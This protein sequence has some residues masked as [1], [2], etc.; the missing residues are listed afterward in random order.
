MNWQG[1]ILVLVIIGL[2]AFTGITPLTALGAALPGVPWSAFVYAAA[3]NLA[4]ML[5]CGRPLPPV[6]WPRAS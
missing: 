4:V 2:P 6:P 5:I 3:V 1:R